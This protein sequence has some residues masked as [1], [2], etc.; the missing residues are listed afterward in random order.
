MGVR[1]RGSRWLGSEVRPGFPGD[2][3]PEGGEPTGPG[4]CRRRFRPGPALGK[5][6][7]DALNTQQVFQAKHGA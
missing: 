2:E 7:C 6:K 4:G 5:G 1:G 3:S